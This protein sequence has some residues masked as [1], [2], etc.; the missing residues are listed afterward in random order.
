MNKFAITMLAA[1]LVCGP[2]ACFGQQD[3][4]PNQ[5]QQQ[6]T[7]KNQPPPGPAQTQ[8]NSGQSGQDVPAEKPGTNNPDISPD[9]K[10]AAPTTTST[11]GKKS[12]RRKR[13]PS[14]TQTAPTE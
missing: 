8:S 6:Q 1:A 9:S 5:Q 12:K 14:S 3:K 2:A 4:N 7:P 11:K 10:P 13:P